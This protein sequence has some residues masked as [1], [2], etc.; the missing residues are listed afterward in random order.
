MSLDLPVNDDTS[1]RLPAI[2]DAGTL[3]TLVERNRAYLRQ[4]L[5]WVDA[6]TCVDDIARF[7]ESAREQTADDRGPV[8]VVIHRDTPAGI[9]G[10]K[11]VDPGNRSAELGYWLAED[12]TGRGIMTACARELVDHAFEALQLNRIEIRAATGNHASR[13]IA[14]RLG[15]SHEGTLQGAERIHGAPVDQ[16]VYS[17]LRQEWSCKHN[18][19]VP[20]GETEAYG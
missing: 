2:D 18:Q 15:F 6:T 16:E 20:G 12:L 10:F 8:C 14:K 13:A 1:L 4:W 5:A 11:P 3:F 17:L 19:P 7:I 9:C